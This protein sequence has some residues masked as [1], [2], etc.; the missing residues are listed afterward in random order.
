MNEN[1]A[2]EESDDLL[3]VVRVC[4]LW[5]DL[6]TR[7]R[8][9]GGASASNTFPP[10]H[11]RIRRVPV[12]IHVYEECLCCGHVLYSLQVVTFLT[13]SRELSLSPLVRHLSCTFRLSKCLKHSSA[14]I[15]SV[16]GPQ[17]AN[18]KTRARPR[19]EI[20]VC[21]FVCFVAAQ[22]GFLVWHSWAVAYARS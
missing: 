10:M 18:K 17:L 2:G 4:D 1:A 21:L 12:C 11:S 16:Q 6:F 3:G 22:H 19:V 9:L 15:L 20:F 5:G 13:T 14:E 7:Q 8:A